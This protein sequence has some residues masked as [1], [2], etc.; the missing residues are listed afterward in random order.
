MS[1]PQ[2]KLYHYVH[3]QRKDIPDTGNYG[4]MT[5]EDIKRIDRFVHENI[6]TSTKCCLYQG[7]V[8][9]TYCTMSYNSK[10]ISVLRLIYHNYV[11]DIDKSDTIEYLCENSGIC[12]N[13]AHFKLKNKP[14]K[15]MKYKPA[16][17]KYT[18][19]VLRPRKSK[20]DLAE[21]NQY[22]LRSYDTDDD[23]CIFAFD[24]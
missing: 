4:K 24:D 8:K 1:S 21:P 19:P 22:K 6:F 14:K 16:V 7:E 17:N 20:L 11:G 3:N 9:K 5:Y 13:L 18:L 10:K 2:L 23:D 12:C 15:E